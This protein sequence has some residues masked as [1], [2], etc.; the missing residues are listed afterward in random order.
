MKCIS[1][2][3]SLCCITLVS[4][5][6]YTQVHKNV[7]QRGNYYKGFEA[8][9]PTTVYESQGRWYL[10]GKK[11]HLRL[12]YPVIY[13]TVFL[14]GGE[15][16]LI[17]VGASLGDAYQEISQGTAIALRERNGYASLPIL[18]REMQGLGATPISALAKN[19]KSHRVN[20][21]IADA[22]T[23]IRVTYANAKNQYRLATKSLSYLT[24]ATV[25]IPGTLLYNISIPLMA[26]FYFFYDNYEEYQKNPFD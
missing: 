11:Y 20:A 3:C 25:D 8:D 21:E 26:P 14:E 7:K 18:Q 15:P 1:L 9:A 24:F 4:S 19:A 2:V 12:H 17:H 13:D 22:D 5:C 10:K 16:S 23:P 6:A